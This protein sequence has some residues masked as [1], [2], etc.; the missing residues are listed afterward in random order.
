MPQDTEGP[1]HPLPDSLELVP[2]KST[3]WKKSLPLPNL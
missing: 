1:L 2:P 3:I